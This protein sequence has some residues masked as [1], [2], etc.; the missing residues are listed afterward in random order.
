MFK[1]AKELRRSLMRNSLKS[2][3]VAPL[4]RKFQVCAVR[5]I[6]IGTLSKENIWLYR[7]KM[8]NLLEDNVFFFVHFCYGWK[9]ESKSREEEK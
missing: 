4:I 1:A 9:Q 7:R 8:E 2:F 5:A 3:V 6:C